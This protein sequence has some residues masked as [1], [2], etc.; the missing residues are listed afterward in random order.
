MWLVAGRL[1]LRHIH[2]MCLSNRQGSSLNR[3]GIRCFKVEIRDFKPIL[4]IM[5]GV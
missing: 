3:N 2:C 1:L 5:F 4:Q